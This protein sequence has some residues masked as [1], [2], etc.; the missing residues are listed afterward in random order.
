[1]EKQGIKQTLEALESL[2]VL[3]KAVKE[4]A[5]DGKVNISDLSVLMS[6]LNN[7]SVFVAGIQG[8]D[9]IGDEIKDLDGDEAKELVVRVGEIVASIKAA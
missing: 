7:M 8:A 5:K 9:K 2:A 3:A 4:V 1:M 6:L